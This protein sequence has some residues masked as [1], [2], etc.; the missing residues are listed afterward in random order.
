MSVADLLSRP[1]VAEIRQHVHKPLSPCW[2]CGCLLFNISR[3]DGSVHCAGCDSGE[4]PLLP[5]DQPS[6]RRHV[7]YRLVVIVQDGQTIG[8][9]IG[10]P[11]SRPTAADTQADAS[12]RERYTSKNPPA[13]CPHCNSWQSP[14]CTTRGWRCRECGREELFNGRVISKGVKP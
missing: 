10:E 6:I 7:A 13:S 9:A 12:E 4:L 5:H 14:S 8:E 1:T 3:A 11:V 2:M